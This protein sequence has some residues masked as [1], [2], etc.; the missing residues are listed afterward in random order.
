MLP[1]GMEYHI[2]QSFG[3]RKLQQIWRLATNLPKFYPP[4]TF[5]LATLLCKAASPPMFIPPK[6]LL[7]AIRQSFV[8][9]DNQGLYD[10]THLMTFIV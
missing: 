5:I 10:K 1:K 2:T 6:C 9:Y 8:P 4:K 3:G 7:V